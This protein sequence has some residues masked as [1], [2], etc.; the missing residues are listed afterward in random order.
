MDDELW[1]PPQARARAALWEAERRLTRGEYAAAGAALEGVVALADPRTAA[2]ARG[3]R[4]IAAAGY[5]QGAGDS[6]R[7]HGHLDRAR[8]R[9]SPYLPVFE[10]VDLEA[11]LRLV[12]DS[13]EP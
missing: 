5:R 11:L 9:L 2:V 6:A 8:A 7:A 3:L 10:E 13:L 4:Q 12:A 1:P